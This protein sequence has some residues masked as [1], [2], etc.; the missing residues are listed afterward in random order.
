MHHSTVPRL[1]LIAFAL[2]ACGQREDTPKKSE[3]RPGSG[4]S[5]VEAIVADDPWA[6]APAGPTSV[7]E[8]ACPRVTSAYFYR[9]EKDGKTS[10]LLGTRH[11]G[12]AWRKM[13]SV[14]HDAMRDSKLVVFETLEDDDAPPRSHRPARDELGPVL[15]Q[16]Y[17][18]LMGED[19]AEKMADESPATAMLFLMIQFEDRFSFL[20]KEIGSEAQRT[21]K[22]IRALETGEF[23]EK[24]LAKVLDTRAVKAFLE[25]V[26]SIDELKQETIEDLTEY[27]S[28]T[29]ET[30]GMDAEDRAEL[31]ESGYTNAEIDAQEKELLSDRNRD[32]IP[33]LGPILAEGGAFIAVGADHLRGDEGVPALLVAKG[34]RVT[35]LTP[36]SP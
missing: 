8:Q 12:V 13:P 9:I 21:H 11:I 4:G 17:Q 14:V 24:L 3:P 18:T 22:P 1:A 6:K 2:L 34:Y 33:K 25:H 30:P 16:R 32:W 7:A 10:H 26:D 15:W 28:G 23:Q 20:E 35:R 5:S 29:D 31:V 27:C 36:P 19:L